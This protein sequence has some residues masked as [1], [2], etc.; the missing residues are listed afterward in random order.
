MTQTRGACI[1]FMG[2][3]LHD[4]PVQDARKILRN[5]VPAMPKDYSTLLL[6]E[7]VISA[8]GCNTQLSALDLVMM[9]LFGSQERT[10]EHWK[11]YIVK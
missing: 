3:V 4:W 6:S 8:T 10:E 11:G 9:T 5:I 2:S 1:Y 7:K